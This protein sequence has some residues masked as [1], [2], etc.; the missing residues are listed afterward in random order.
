MMKT[1]VFGD[2]CFNDNVNVTQEEEKT[3]LGGNLTLSLL[4]FS[5]ANITI[6][7]L[8]WSFLIYS[9]FK[10]TLSWTFLFPNSL[11]FGL[12][13]GSASSLAQVYFTHPSTISF[14]ST[15]LG[16]FSSTLIFSSLLV[17]LVYI[18]SLNK[19]MHKLP[20][21]YQ[22]LLLFFCV[23]VQ[24]AVSTQSLLITKI[25]ANSCCTN[26]YFTNML[27]TVYPL[28]MLLSTLCLST[29]LRRR[30]E[31]KQEARSIWILSILSLAMKI[32]TKLS[33]TFLIKE[34]SR[35]IQGEL[36]SSIYILEIHIESYQG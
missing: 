14:I 22:T 18:H 15:T 11:L 27:S 17:R 31:F 16:P 12:F 23:L 8:Y 19:D 26:M 35:Q 25:K 13:T 6:V 9:S 33:T 29:M 7:F 34:Y 1:T 36:L 2:E 21:L 20:T 3:F 4:V 30:K 28:F 32:I 10:N 5:S 24:V